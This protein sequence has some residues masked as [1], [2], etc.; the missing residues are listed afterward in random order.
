MENN[1]ILILT[2]PGGSG[3]S[4]VAKLLCSNYGYTLVDGDALDTEYFPKGG[5]SLPENKTKLIKAHDKILREAK[6]QFKTGKNIVVEYII[7]GEYLNFFNK[8]K[9]TFGNKVDIKILFPSEEETILRDK[10]RSCWTTGAERIKAVRKEF[11]EIK[12]TIG[13]QNFIDTTE[14]KPEETTRLLL[15][16]L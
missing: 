13:I 3:K 6:K 9:N 10:E 16:Q 15:S 14:Q 12:D 7:F 4:T 5:Q 2:G 8:F 1:K 11:L